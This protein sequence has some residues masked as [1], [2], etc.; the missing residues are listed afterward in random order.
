[1]RI[2]DRAEFAELSKVT[3]LLGLPD[4]TEV[5][6][7][8][9]NQLEA[10]PASLASIREVASGL[11]T[12]ADELST[13]AETV[14]WTGEAANA[15][16]AKA[17]AGVDALKRAASTIDEF[18]GQLDVTPEQVRDII[19]TVLKYLGAAVALAAAIGTL[20]AAA[21]GVIAGT[22]GVGAL[23]L[24]IAGLAVVVLAIYGLLFTDFP[25]LSE[26]IAAAINWILDKLCP[27]DPPRQV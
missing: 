22:V 12:A 6:P 9:E 3:K 8:L 27:D 19:L 20:I 15:F 5:L 10:V 11:R 13:Q 4:P 7:K 25:V 14:A 17:A 21:S 24:A 18:A 26:G 16:R 2:P 23:L 1:M